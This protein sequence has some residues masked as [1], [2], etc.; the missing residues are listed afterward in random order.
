[1]SEGG[2]QVAVAQLLLPGQLALQVLELDLAQLHVAA[3]LHHF[4]RCRVGRDL[5]QRL[6]LFDEITD[7][8][9]AP[10]HHTGEDG[11]DADFDPGLDGAD[12][13]CLVDQGAAHDRHGFGT[14]VFLPPSRPVAAMAPRLRTANTVARMMIVRR[15]ISGRLR[16]GA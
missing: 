14:S 11:F 1:M 2:N 6:A 9:E 16:A 12:G 13:E 15:F 4:Q 8:G 3:Q 7:G 5:E 10:P